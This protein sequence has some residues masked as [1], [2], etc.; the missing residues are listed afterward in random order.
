M[1]TVRTYTVEVPPELRDR[2]MAMV[3]KNGHSASEII[4]EYMAAYIADQANKKT[5]TKNG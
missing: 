2:F 4:R 5:E 1:T 3:K